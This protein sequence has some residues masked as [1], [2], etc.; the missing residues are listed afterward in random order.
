MPF[1][2]RGMIS[3]VVHL[4]TNHTSSCLILNDVF[5]RIIKYKSKKYIFRASYN[6]VVGTLSKVSSFYFIF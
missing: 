3:I 4:P 1:K 5:V 6:D 2:L